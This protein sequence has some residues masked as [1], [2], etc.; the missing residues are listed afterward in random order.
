MEKN[1]NGKGNQQTDSKPKH[2][3]FEDGTKK[4]ET[5]PANPTAKQ[6]GQ[7]DSQQSNREQKNSSSPNGKSNSNVDNTD[8]REEKTTEVVPSGKTATEDTKKRNY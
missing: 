6:D 1:Q 5:N 8:E 2:E 4:K 3:T 7:K